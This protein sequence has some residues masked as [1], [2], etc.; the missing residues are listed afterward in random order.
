M[1]KA[2]KI[3]KRIRTEVYVG[4]LLVIL[5]VFLIVTAVT[6][7]KI[8]LSR[9]AHY[10][11]K[12][13]CEDIPVCAS[14]EGKTYEDYRMITDET[15]K[16]YQL[17]QKRLKVDSKTGLLYDRDGFLAVALGYT[18]GEVGT[19]YYFTLDS[20]I[21][22]PLIKTD[23][24]DPKDASN[25]CEVDINGTV[26]EFVLDSDIALNY[27]GTISN[28]LILDGNLNNSP[29]FKGSIQRIERIIE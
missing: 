7:P 4:L 27:F 22:L 18:F 2:L 13:K 28:G 20:G 29:Y 1:N 23:E 11:K 12:M 3:L 26:I 25:G 15:S 10:E 17:I 9:F 5:L 24:K 19:R 16:Q 14:H 6:S 8:N 21:V